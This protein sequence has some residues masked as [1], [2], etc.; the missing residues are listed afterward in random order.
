MFIVKE[1]ISIKEIKEKHNHFF[2]TMVKIV[3]DLEQNIIA[4]DSEMH[5]DC[6]QLLLENRSKQSNLWGA[7]IYFE[8]AN[9]VEF[10]SLINIRPSQNNKSMEVQDE[11]LKQQIQ[12][13]VDKLII[14]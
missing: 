5:A 6:E 10:T 14:W 8:K 1:P 4:I 9:F 13:I 2:E 11:N 3:I 7:N 12:Q